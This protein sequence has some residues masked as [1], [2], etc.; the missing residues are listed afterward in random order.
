MRSAIVPRALSAVAIALLASAAPLAQATASTTSTRTPLD[1]TVGSSCSPELVDITGNVHVVQH[2]TQNGQGLRQMVHLNADGIGV[3]QVSGDHYV[4]SQSSNQVFNRHDSAA[5][6][7]TNTETIHVIRSGPGADFRLHAV[8][9]VTITPD[10]T[11]T[12]TVEKLER[13]CD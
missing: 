10:G 8:T 3:G 4:F 5:L 11:I 13:G 2:T 12:A 1:G 9:H 6:E 7:F